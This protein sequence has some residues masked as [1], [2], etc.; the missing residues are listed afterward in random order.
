MVIRTDSCCAFRRLL[1]V[2]EG[3]MLPF[4]SI[5]LKIEIFFFF[6]LEYNLTQ[7]E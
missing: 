3:N 5:I 1:L 2:L 4:L 7:D 6:K